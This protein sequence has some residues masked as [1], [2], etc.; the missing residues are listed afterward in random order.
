[1]KWYVEFPLIY[2]AT[3]IILYILNNNR[4]ADATLF[5]CVV[6][7]FIVSAFIYAGIDGGRKTM[8]KKIKE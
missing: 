6:F 4:W 5:V 2:L 1:M 8:N 7:G 3:V